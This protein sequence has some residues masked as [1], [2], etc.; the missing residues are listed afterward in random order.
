[1]SEPDIFGLLTISQ[2]LSVLRIGIGLWWLKSVFHKRIRH[3]LAEGMISW[4]VSLAENH[5]VET[6][7]R[8]MKRMLLASKSWFPYFQLFGEF[9]V[10]VGLTLGFLTPAAA[11][12]GIFMNL[13]FLALAGVRPKDKSVNPCF[14]VEQGQ[15]WN[16]ILGETVV[17]AAGAWS[18]WSLDGLL[19]LF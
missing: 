1:M 15:N 14:R 11:L 7:G 16:M 12:A 3:F 5:P 2:W 13:N 6:Y 18:T 4:T 19:G 8:F 17:V 10:G 9:A